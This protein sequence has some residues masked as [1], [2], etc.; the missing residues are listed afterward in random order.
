MATN[1]EGVKM[2]KV[3]SNSLLIL[4]FARWASI[5]FI[6]GF[7]EEKSQDSLCQFLIETDVLLSKN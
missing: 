6:F 5:F 1:L 4:I 3:G 7:D 2:I